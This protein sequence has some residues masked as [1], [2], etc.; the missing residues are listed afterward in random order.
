MNTHRRKLLPMLAVVGVTVMILAIQ[1]GSR[2]VQAAAAATVDDLPPTFP[3]FLYGTVHVNDS[4]VITG[5]VVSAWCGGVKVAQS[6]TQDQEGDAWYGMDIP[7]DDPETTSIKEGCVDDEVVS[8]TIDGVLAAQTVLWEAGSSIELHI[9]GT[10]SIAVKKDISPDQIT[11]YPAN[12]VGAA[13][14]LIVGDPLWWRIGVT[15]TGSLT[16]TLTMTD[17]YSSSALSLATACAPPPP[18]T[19][20]HHP[21]AGSSYQCV[22]SGTVAEGAHRNVVTATLTYETNTITGAD[23]AYYQGTT[24]TSVYLPL[25]LR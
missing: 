18:T 9:T 19:L 5:T 3:L 11:W 14:F 7:G 22:L 16:A 17:V 1:A 8:L 15:N 13:P 24:K 12:D 20:A 2:P 6:T 21:Q 23:G 25:V 10:L 4:P